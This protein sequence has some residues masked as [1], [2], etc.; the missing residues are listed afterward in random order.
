MKEQTNSKFLYNDPRER[1]GRMNRFYIPITMVIW[2]LFLFYLWLKVTMQSTQDI[3]YG[4]VYVNTALILVFAIANLIVYKRR[5]TSKRLCYVMLVEVAVEVAI[6]GLG[7]DADFVFFAML[8]VLALQIPYFVPK[9]MWRMGILYTLL[10]IVIVYG[11]MFMDPQNMNVDTQLKLMFI[12]TSIF[13]L[14]RVGKLATQFND[15]ALGTVEHQNS[16]QQRLLGNI[17]DISKTVAEGTDTSTDLIAQLVDITDRVAGNMNEISNA[18][19]ITAEN[20][21]EQNMMTQSIQAA[22][23]D[24]GS[25]SRKMVVV[26]QESEESIRINVQTMHDLTEESEVL[27]NTNKA[28][29]DAMDKLNA[30]V[31]EVSDIVS[32][33]MNVSNQTNL[34]ALNASIESARA[35]EAG[36]GFAVVADQIRQL[37]EQTKSSLGEITAI[38][39][40]LSG[41]AEEVMES[42]NNSATATQRQREKILDA[43]GSFEKL[44]TNM[45]QL[46]GEVQEIDLQISGLSTSNNRIVENII[47]LSAMTQEVSAGAE[48]MGKLTAGSKL[49]A[50]QVKETVEAIKNK[51]DELKEFI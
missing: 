42:V 13:A 46:I 14:C 37:A 1:I 41:N 15:H 25:R 23:D 28:V 35:G 3:T 50:D 22:I 47:Q 18:T 27:N 19:G 34:L 2:A 12:L 21:E 11:R 36:R 45:S 4:Y 7:T 44:G 38:I 6:I 5:R 48:E 31:Q 30:K 20:I 29:S 24:A 9:V 51:T 26:A 32:I 39:D 49:L 40:E 33:I 10:S 16:K 8:A 43:A 17:M